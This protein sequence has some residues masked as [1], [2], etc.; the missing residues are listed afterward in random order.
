MHFLGA[1][2][3]GNDTSGAEDIIDPTANMRKSRNTSSTRG[4]NS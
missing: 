4:M 1:V 2:I 3:G